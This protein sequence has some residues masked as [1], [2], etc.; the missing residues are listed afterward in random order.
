MSYAEQYKK[1]VEDFMAG[2]PEE[3]RATVAKSFEYIMASDFGNK[4]LTRGDIATD[5]T[6]PNAR[7]ET[8][9]LYELLKKGPVVLNFYR[10]GWCPFCSLEFKSVHDILPQIK[11][12]GATLVGISPELP[13]NS[14]DTIE[15]NQLQFEVLSDVGNN[16]ARQ[17]GIVMEVPEV[18]R[19]LYLEWGLDIPK[20]NGDETWELPIPATYVI[21]TD[22]KIVSAYVNKNYTERME[23]YEIVMALKTLSQASRQEEPT[24]R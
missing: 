4:A 20:I 3:A 11:E 10:G 22:G 15:K 24:T 16:I 5:F 14:L 8:T 1:I 21:N 7:G 2:L 12:Q 6:L 18:I 9:R 19:P 17:Y 13:D 23:P